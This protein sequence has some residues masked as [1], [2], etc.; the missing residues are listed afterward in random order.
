MMADV[1]L[2]NVTMI[3]KDTPAVKDVNLKVADGEFLVL[4]GPSGCG[5]TTTLRMIAGLEKPTT[6]DVYIGDELVNDV[7]PKDRDIAMVFQNYALYPHMTVRDNLAFPLKM[8]KFSKSEID[9]KVKRAAEILEISDLLNRRPKQLSGG[10]RQRVALGRSIVREP[11]VFLMDEP[12]S[13]LDAKL[14][15]QTRIEIKALQKKIG[16]TMI[17]VTHDQ[18]EAMTL[19]DR[20][21][22]MKDGMIQQVGPPTAVY[23]HPSNKFV[24]GFMGSPAMNFFDGVL[25]ENNARLFVSANDQFQIPIDP[26]IY[27]TLRAQGGIPGRGVTYGIRAEDVGVNLNQSDGFVNFTVFGSELM[28][29]EQ[30]V[31]A[32]NG[33]ERI[34]ARAPMTFPS[35]MGQ[36]VWMNLS[37]PNAHVFDNESGKSLV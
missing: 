35:V 27:D 24:A 21:A 2:K 10:Q 33:K 36:A 26:A 11:K 31:Y 1:T 12:L 19:A 16:T 8:R 13:N 29:A 9:S 23:S 28:G 17:Y 32:M 25:V 20:V 14:R 22:V 30:F 18:A 4:L 37:S 6:G 15:V 7:P 5:K 34:V 3:F